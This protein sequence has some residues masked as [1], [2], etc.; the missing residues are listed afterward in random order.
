VAFASRFDQIGVLGRTVDDAALGLETDRRIRQVGFDEL[1]SRF[2]STAGPRSAERRRIRRV[3]TT[4]R[5]AS[6][7]ARYRSPSPGPRRFRGVIIGKPKE[8]FPDSLDASTKTCG[9]RARPVSARWARR[10][11][12]LAPRSPL[13]IPSTTFAPAEASS[14]LPA[15]TACVTDCASIPAKPEGDVRSHEGAGFGAEVIRRVLS[16]LYVS[17]PATTTRT[18]KRRRWWNPHRR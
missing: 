2:R 5:F 12:H 14:I 6:D 11:E 3:P 17:L 7:A 18:T 4:K 1:R 15:S 13:A 16:G 9:A 10:F 8:Y